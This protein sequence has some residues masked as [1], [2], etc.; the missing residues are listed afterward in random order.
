MLHVAAA[1]E[2]FDH[3]LW[4]AATDERREELAQLVAAELGSESLNMR[5]CAATVRRARRWRCSCTRRSAS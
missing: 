5:A 3:T 2:L 1:P 4:A